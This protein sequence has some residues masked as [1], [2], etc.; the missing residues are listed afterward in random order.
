MH[1]MRSGWPIAA[2]SCLLLGA[3]GGAP[4][5]VITRDYVASASYPANL[6]PQDIPR[7]RVLVRI[8]RAE[9][10]SD[11]RIVVTLSF[12]GHDAIAVHRAYLSGYPRITGL[13]HEYLHLAHADG[14]PIPA[15]PVPEK[16]R[17]AV[18]VT[19]SF[20][21]M[22]MGV[23]GN[24]IYAVGAFEVPVDADKGPITAHLDKGIRDIA[25]N[26]ITESPR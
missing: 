14:T 1:V 17:Y 26:L 2:A 24:V 11:D 5:T 25:A 20:E 15:A 16:P 9:F 22:F 18:R 12:S 19:E 21:P 13:P 6:G 3:C 4:R 8:A 7:D 23:I 10:V